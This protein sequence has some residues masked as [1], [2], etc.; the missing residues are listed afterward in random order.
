MKSKNQDLV[1]DAEEANKAIVDMSQFIQG[2]SE[3]EKLKS[4]LKGRKLL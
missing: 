1:I 4:M 2:P 3:V